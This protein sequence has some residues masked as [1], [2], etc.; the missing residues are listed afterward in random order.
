MW[1]GV[2]S[3]PLLRKTS[4]GRVDATVFVCHRRLDRPTVEIIVRRR[5]SALQEN[6][7]RQLVSW[8]HRIADSLGQAQGGCGSSRSRTLGSGAVRAG[9]ARRKPPPT[10][11]CVLQTP[12]MKRRFAAAL[13][14]GPGRD[15]KGRAALA[16]DIRRPEDVVPAEIRVASRVLVAEPGRTRAKPN[17]VCP[18]KLPPRRQA[19]KPVP[20]EA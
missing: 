11:R 10:V 4:V 16:A 5:T 7:A 2:N 13:G 20:S 9:L 17:R 12:P 15:R 6:V 3:H 8:Q 1:G 18:A 14:P 19:R